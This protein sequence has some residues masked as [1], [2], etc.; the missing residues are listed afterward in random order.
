MKRWMILPAVAL[1]VG[2]FTPAQAEDPDVPG[3]GSGCGATEPVA[4]LVVGT[5]GDVDSRDWYDASFASGTQTLEVRALFVPYLATAGSGVK[6]QF[7]KW[8]KGNNTCSRI[9]IERC[10]TLA[11]FDPDPCQPHN[12]PSSGGAATYTFPA[13]GD[14]QVEVGALLPGFAA[15]VDLVPYIIRV[16]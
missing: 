3:S 4:P 10:G 1:I 7:Y 8:D 12:F 11:D 2:A 14:Y 16:N 15:V 13:P 5:V 9:A 6:V